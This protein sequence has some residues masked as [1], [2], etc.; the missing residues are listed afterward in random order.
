[1]QTFVGALESEEVSMT[2]AHG[3]EI[4]AAFRRARKAAQA[5]ASTR[6]TELAHKHLPPS[7]GVSAA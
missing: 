3:R 2:Q 5:R 7:I 4:G 6:L 1:M